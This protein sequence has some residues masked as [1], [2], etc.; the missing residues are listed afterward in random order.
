MLGLQS[1]ES[2]IR[3][4][5]A[6]LQSLCVTVRQQ[7]GNPMSPQ[8][9]E[10]AAH[11][12]LN[13]QSPGPD[14]SLRQLQRPRGLMRPGTLA[15][16]IP[17]ELMFPGL[18]GDEAPPGGVAGEPFRGSPGHLM[19]GPYS[20]HHGWR[21]WWC[22]I[23]RRHRPQGQ[24]QSEVE[25]DA[26]GDSLSQG[27]IVKMSGAGKASAGTVAGSPVVSATQPGTTV[28]PVA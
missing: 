22:G 15:R 21:W 12:A 25:R 2:G 16:Q 17:S 11:C 23:Y 7:C 20:D 8:I 18:A 24:L 28:A 1:Y 6:L 4:H 9:A 27:R 5:P 19:R 14:L 26:H 10:W 3:G 13:P